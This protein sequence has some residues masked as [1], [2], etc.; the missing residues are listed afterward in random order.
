LGDGV[1]N[2]EVDFKVNDL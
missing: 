2:E 1:T